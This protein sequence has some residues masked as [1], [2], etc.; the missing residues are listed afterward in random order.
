MKVLLVG[1]SGHVGSM[2][3]PYMKAHH[4]FRILDLSPPKDS[5]VDYI[6]GSVTDPRD[7]TASHQR[8]GYFCLYGDATPHQRQLI[9]RRFR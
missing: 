6:Q 7:C 2:T 3:L 1:G 9:R 5:T 4:Q 8:D